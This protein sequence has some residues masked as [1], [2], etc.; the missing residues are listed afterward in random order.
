MWVAVTLVDRGLRCSNHLSK[1]NAAG[2]LAWQPKAV[3]SGVG[4]HA[5]PATVHVRGRGRVE[6]GATLHAS[7][8]QPGALHTTSSATTD[9]ES[10]KEQS[11]GPI[12][13]WV[14]SAVPRG[15]S[16]VA[17]APAVCDANAL[18]RLG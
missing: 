5:V 10:G 15:A 16:S 6:A 9:L 18:F 17:G 7:G 11:A 13:G 14:T 2:Q 12:I 8:L 1:A 3:I 4:C